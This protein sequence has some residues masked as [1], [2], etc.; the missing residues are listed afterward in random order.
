V[1]T[2]SKGFKQ[3]ISRGGFLGLLEF[4]K[5]YK[6]LFFI[7]NRLFFVFIDLQKGVFSPQ[8]RIITAYFKGSLKNEARRMY[9]QD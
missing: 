2:F 5:T 4:I 9:L 3:G 6:N 1:H 8:G 7:K